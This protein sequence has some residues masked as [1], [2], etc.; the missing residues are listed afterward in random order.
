M[1]DWWL[2]TQNEWTTMGVLSDGAYGVPEGLVFGFPVT[3]VNGDYRIVPGLTIDAFTR[4]MIDANAH[5]LL[6]ELAIVKPLLPA[7][8]A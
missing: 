6:A 4:R 1:R 2:G 8:F 3:T 7:L 5:E